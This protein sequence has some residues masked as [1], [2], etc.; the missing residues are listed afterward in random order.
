[1]VASIFVVIIEQKL[2]VLKLY[3]QTHTHN[4]TLKR[5]FSPIIVLFYSFVRITPTVRCAITAFACIIVLL[6]KCLILAYNN[7][8]ACVYLSY[9]H[10]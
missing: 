6:K 2:I 8:L 3:K 5:E 1:M 7:F 9:T 4:M 10:H